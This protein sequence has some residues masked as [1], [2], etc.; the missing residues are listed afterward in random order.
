MDILLDPVLR[1]PL[2][3]CAVL[4]G[5][6]AAIGA[7]VVFRQQSLMTEVLSHACY[8]GM[9]IGAI[10]AEFLFAA[11][12]T[13]KTLLLVISGA[14]TTSILAVYGVSWLQKKGRVTSD[15][16]LS[17]VLSGSFSIGLLCISMSQSV[18]PDL[19]RRLQT[20][21]VGQAA[22]MSNRYIMTA[23]A[24]FFVVTCCIMV[25][26]R[27]LLTGLFDPDFGR[28]HALVR[29]SIET[30]F[31][32]LLVLTVTFGMRTL[33]VLLMTAIFIFPAISARMI[34]SS[35]DRLLTTAAILGSLCGVVGLIISHTFA[36]SFQ[37]SVGKPLFLPTGP[38]IVLVHIVVFSA[39]ALFSPDYGLCVRLWRRWHFLERCHRENI[40]KAL[41]KECAKENSS[42][43]TM[44]K[45]FELIPMPRSEMNRRLRRLQKSRYLSLL[46]GYIEVLPSGMLLGRTLVRLHRLWE[47]YLVRFCGMPKDRVHP[48]AEEMEH[49]LTPEVEKELTLLLQNPAMDPHERPIPSSEQ[50]LALGG[51][52]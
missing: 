22:T 25:F 37:E 47:L 48:S 12:E 43:V 42:R 6:S 21:L 50:T 17:C 10:V 27:S 29:S 11:T 23:C 5:L 26:R 45:L 28:L 4:G 32:L 52:L 51:P 31:S 16:A 30:I 3:M 46:D 41:W 13:E 20:L 7:L 8:P 15:S 33:G 39:I 38:S 36:L 18:F 24:L 35:F 2:L 1:G 49:I 14:I 34:T 9:I 19:W 44:K 40:M